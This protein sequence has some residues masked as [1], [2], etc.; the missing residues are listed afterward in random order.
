MQTLEKHQSLTF[1][2]K[3]VFLQNLIFSS[4]EEMSSKFKKSCLIPTILVENQPLTELL[5]FFWSNVN[6]NPIELK[7]YI[8]FKLFRFYQT[9]SMIGR[10]VWPGSFERTVNSNTQKM[11]NSTNCFGLSFYKKIINKFVSN[12]IN[13]LFIVFIYLLYLLRYTEKYECN[14][15]SKYQK[16]ALH[17]NS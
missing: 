5:T 12:L 14:T 6:W 4:W 1:Y 13:Q 2:Q 15:K 3:R 11:K 17:H 10:V 8:T 9:L 7:F 16:S